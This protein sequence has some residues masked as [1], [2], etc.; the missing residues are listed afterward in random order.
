MQNES[1]QL[2]ITESGEMLVKNDRQKKV[3]RVG[4]W[5]VKD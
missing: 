1:G 4:G 3:E 5:C 2:N